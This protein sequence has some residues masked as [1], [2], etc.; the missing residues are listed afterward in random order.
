VVGQAA[1]TRQPGP[2]TSVEGA[3]QALLLRYQPL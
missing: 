1:G 2:R 3:G